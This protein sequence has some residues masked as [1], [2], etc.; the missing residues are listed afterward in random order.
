M[1][2]IYEA[3]DDGERDD[4]D[5]K[6]NGRKN[7]GLDDQSQ[8]LTTRSSGRGHTRSRTEITRAHPQRDAALHGDR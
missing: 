4:D 5:A 7:Y 3:A 6:R 1:S 2:E 8:M